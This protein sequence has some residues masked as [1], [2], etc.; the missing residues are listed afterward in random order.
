MIPLKYE[1]LESGK[2][3]FST[4]VSKIG[5]TEG[6]A[7]PTWYPAR[8][9]RMIEVPG[10]GRIRY[11]LTT[12]AFEPNVPLEDDSFRFKFPTGTQVYDFIIGVQYLMGAAG[13][14]KPTAFGDKG[15]VTAQPPGVAAPD[16]ATGGE[17]TLTVA[18]VASSEATASVGSVPPAREITRAGWATVMLGVIV[19]SVA[20]W[21]LWR[22]RRSVVRKGK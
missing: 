21:V 16:S 1:E 2:V 4:E 8:A 19:A 6:E 18:K 14:D 15:R 5:Q 17:P 7:G 11:E 13:P 10:A 12:R 20:V 3:S 9:M 22:Y